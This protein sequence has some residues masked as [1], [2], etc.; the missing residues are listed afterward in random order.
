MNS[1]EAI[2]W[3]RTAEAGEYL[4][5]YDDDDLDDVSDPG[6]RCGFDDQTLDEVESVL[7]DRGLTLTATDVGLEV[8]E[9]TEDRRYG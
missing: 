6:S 1:S 2:I 5:E 4:A 3:A 9:R 8:C 7:R